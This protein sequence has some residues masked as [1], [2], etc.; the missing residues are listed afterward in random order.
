[1]SSRLYSKTREKFLTAQ[2]SWLSGSYRGL[3]LPDSYT[4]DFGD[5]F[6]SDVFEGVRI[7]VSEEITG[8]TATNGVANCDAIRWP[9]LV[10]SRLASKI[11]IF[12]DTGVESTSDLICFID[13]EDIVGAPLALVGFDYF[14][15]PN[16]VE[17]GIFRL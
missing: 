15:M 6:F 13:T 11:I 8:Q 3:L 1:M 7:A 4:P 16:A 5:E 2:L 10:D 17:G 12:K 9:L 14:F